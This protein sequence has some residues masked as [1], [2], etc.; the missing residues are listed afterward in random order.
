LV[1][2]T[3]ADS[4][5]CYEAVH[6]K[7]DAAIASDADYCVIAG[8]DMLLIKDFS[9]GQ[10]KKG[11]AIDNI[12]LAAG[13][14]SILKDAIQDC[15][16]MDESSMIKDA[17]YPVLETDDVMHPSVV[18]VLMKARNFEVILKEY[19]VATQ[20]AKPTLLPLLPL[21][22][23]YEPLQNY[24]FQNPA[25]KGLSKVLGAMGEKKEE[26]KENSTPLT[27]T[28][29][30]MTTFDPRYDCIVEAIDILYALLEGHDKADDFLDK[31]AKQS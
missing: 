4:V 30:V 23:K 10:S 21:N 24:W 27:D 12:V 13:V 14:R 8:K 11:P 22:T 2:K 7:I 6:K 28:H 1:G 15:L 18:A 25:Q 29:M 26:K 19:S 3:Q 5:I 20:S 9:F 31:K 16:G 17:K